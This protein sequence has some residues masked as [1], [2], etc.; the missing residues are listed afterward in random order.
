V[1][2]HDRVAG[3]TERVSRAGAGTEGDGASVAPSISE[4]GR[5][6]AF[7]SLAA[8]LVSGD[9][10]RSA[11]IFVRDRLTQT[12]E[13]LC[14]AVQ[15]DRFSITPAISADATVVAFAAAATKLVPGDTNRRLDIFTC[16]RWRSLRIIPS[17]TTRWIVHLPALGSTVYTPRSRAGRDRLLRVAR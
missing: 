4:N 1:F 9:D 7:H 8:N 6:V 14:G 11:D 16:D 12:V 2:V 13:R 10:N 17:S 3:T 5:F 15:G